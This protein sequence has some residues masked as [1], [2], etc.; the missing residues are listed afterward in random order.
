MKIS[1]SGSSA[2]NLAAFAPTDEEPHQRHQ[3]QDHHNS[4]TVFAD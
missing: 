2:L 1:K 3:Q 4:V